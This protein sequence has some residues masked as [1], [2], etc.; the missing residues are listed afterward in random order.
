MHLDIPKKKRCY[1]HLIHLYFYLDFSL[2]YYTYCYLNPI[3]P[4]LCLVHLQLR[5]DS[6]DTANTDFLR[7]LLLLRIDD[8]SVINDE[9]I[10]R[11]SLTQSPAD[12]LAE[13][14]LAVAEEQDLLGA[15]LDIVRLAPGAHD[16]GV[17]VSDASDDVDTLGEEILALFN[18]SGEMAGGAARGEGAGDREKDDLLIGPFSGGVV[19]YREAAGCE[20]FGRRVVR[21]VAWRFFF[22]YMS[23]IG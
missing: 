11:A 8:F 6:I 18:V 7:N 5:E 4:N 19:G 16:E 22:S 10:P 12:L 23:S 1:L 9:R 2:L 14:Q 13:C 21:D 3:S 17:V 20:G 15:V